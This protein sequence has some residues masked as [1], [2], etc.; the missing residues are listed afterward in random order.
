[1]PKPQ[2]PYLFPE[3]VTYVLAGGL[4]GLGRSIARWMVSRGARHL[5][6]LSRK[7][8]SSDAARE[9]VE[10][11]RE[12]G[13]MVNA[14]ACDVSDRQAL[15]QAISECEKSMPPIKGCIQGAMQLKVR[16]YLSQ[17]T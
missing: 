15:E 9:L 17:L 6:F 13:C 7:G 16:F 4:G 12:N 2:T 3:N 1:V 10:D 8:A 5:V 14:V 11:L